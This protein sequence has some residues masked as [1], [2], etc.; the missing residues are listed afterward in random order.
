[1][2][3]SDK[4]ETTSFPRSPLLIDK[5]RCCLLV[6]DVQEKLFSLIDRHEDIE[7]ALHSLVAGARCFEVPIFVSEQYPERL[8]GT[9]SSLAANL[10]A[11]SS[12]RMFSCRECFDSWQH[13]LPPTRDTLILSGIEA[14]V[15][16][17]QTALDLVGAGW[18][19]VVLADAVG[20]RWPI[21]CTIALERM[22]WSGC[23]ITTVESLLFEWCESSLDPRFRELSAIIKSRSRSGN[24]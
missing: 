10:P 6:I 16:V 3:D 12:K 11:A 7:S 18:N 24:A 5:E 8:G 19:V 23:T 9:I 2:P 15:C 14:H 1:M 4:C 21:D 17:Q 22:R 20:S 13:A